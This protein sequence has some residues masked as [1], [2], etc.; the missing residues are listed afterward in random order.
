MSQKHD[1]FFKD[2]ASGELTQKILKSAQVE[3][4]HNRQRKKS[5]VWFL[6][7][8]PVLATVAA[9]VFIF[10]INVSQNFNK[11]TQVLPGVAVIEDVNEDV[12]NTSE[13]LELASVIGDDFE[14]VEMV[15]ELGLLQEFD[16]IELI[17]DEELEG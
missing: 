6:I 11:N 14:A 1:D 16:E 5:K 9:S 17:T 2:S 4:G 13:Q 3:L 7:I 12:L 10:K 8:G 15:D